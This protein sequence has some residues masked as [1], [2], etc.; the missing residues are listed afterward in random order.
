MELS[1]DLHWWILGYVGWSVPGDSHWEV[2]EGR[3]CVVTLQVSLVGQP[4]NQP[5]WYH[6]FLF[7]QPRELASLFTDVAAL[8]LQFY[9]ATSGTYVL[10]LF[11]QTN[12]YFTIKR[13]CWC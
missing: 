3:Y 9:P 10:S 11:I 12:Q 5:S 13:Y 2:H 8:S 4:E 7:T 6:A 1:A